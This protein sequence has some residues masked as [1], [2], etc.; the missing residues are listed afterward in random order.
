MSAKYGI[1]IEIYNQATKAYTI[2][3]TR[4]LA[5]VGD[6]VKK[7]NEWLKYYP[8][9]DE[10]LKSVGNGS[11]K[12]ALEDLKASGINTTLILSS[13]VKDTQEDKNQRQQANIGKALLAMEVLLQAEQATGFKPKF[14]L[15]PTYNNQRG[16]WEEL[17]K[18]GD[19]LGAVYALEILEIQ[20]DKINAFIKDFQSKRAIITYQM[21]QRSDL[22]IRP[23]ANF[24]IA[25]Y[26]KVMN[27]SEYGFA[28][29]FSNRIIDGVASIV[30]TVEFIS[31]EDCRADRLRSKGITMAISDDGIRS[32]GGETTDPDFPSIHSA[33]IFDTII[34][35]IAKSQKEAIDK[36]VSDTLKKVV[37]DLEAF[38]RK[39]IANN[40]IIG[41]SVSVPEN[42][43]TNE[44]IAEGKIYIE[45]KAQETPIIKNIT[46]KIYKVDSY[47][48]E[49]VKE[50]N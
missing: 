3:N 5:I 34:E 48:A 45:H 32:W 42:L 30:D 16:F 50:L 43:N 2:N 29:T 24:I 14:I 12:D 39:L 35:T 8:S 1:N 47:G 33:V 13:F 36:Q 11:I 4:T 27:Q 17:K 7:E 19:K 10:A 41:F 46:N 49:L 22:V 31:G 6:D 9:I 37:D 23:L 15:A 44:S 38:Y 20:E 28:Q 26:I 21:V 25:Q 40:V 18:V